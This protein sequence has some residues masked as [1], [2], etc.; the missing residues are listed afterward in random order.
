MNLSVVG[1]TSGVYKQTTENAPEIPNFAIIQNVILAGTR[2]TSPAHDGNS[3][4]LTG[5]RRT[6][7]FYREHCD[8]ANKTF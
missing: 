5:R 7:E 3:E 8:V 6:V 1:K 2:D 4:T